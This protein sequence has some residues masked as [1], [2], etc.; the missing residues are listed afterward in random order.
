MV[1]AKTSTKPSSKGLILIAVSAGAAEMLADLWTRTW[2][3]L[4]G[5]VGA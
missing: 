5:A 1:G 4:Y 3:Q 2:A